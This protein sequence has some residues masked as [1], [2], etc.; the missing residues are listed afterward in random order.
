M[1]PSAVQPSQGENRNGE[2]GNR[3]NFYEV[4]GVPRAAS[5]AQINDAFR[6][7]AV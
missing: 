5:K 3:T 6:K 2:T 7:M 1:E 4:L